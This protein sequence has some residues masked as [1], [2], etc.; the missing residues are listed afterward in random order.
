MRRSR[1]SSLRALALST[2]PGPSLAVT[3]ITVMLGIG[4]GVSPERLLLLGLA[5]LSGQ[6]SVGLSNDW[7]DAARDRES[8]RHDKPVASGAL[9]ELGAQRGALACAAAALVFTMP[10]GAGA[11]LVHGI[12]LAAGWAYNLGV[13]STVFSIA[14]YLVAFGLLPLLVTVSRHDHAWAAPWAMVAGALLGASAHFA[15][16]LPDLEDDRRAG[17]R[18]LPHRL[19]ARAAGLTTYLL[20][21]MAAVVVT[22]GSGIAPPPWLWLGLLANLAIAAWGVVLVLTRTPSRLM[23]RLIM[24]SALITVVLLVLSGGRMLAS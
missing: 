19:G 10:L 4:V 23:F 14:P 3:A 22:F 20:L 9:S 8:G 1:W 18:G 6:A 21:A 7:L 15:N 5:M 16:V 2:H 12:F 11:I 17:V 24:A 13:K